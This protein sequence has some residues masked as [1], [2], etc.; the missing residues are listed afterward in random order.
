MPSRISPHHERPA[1]QPCRVAVHVFDPDGKFLHL[2]KPKPT[3]FPRELWSTTLTITDQGHVYL[4]LGNVS[5]GRRGDY[6]HFSADGKR[7]GTKRLKTEQWYFQPGTGNGLAL[8]YEEAYLVNPAGKTIR[9]IKRRPDGNWLV[10]PHHASVAPDGSFAI[11]TYFQTP[12]TVNIYKADGEPVRTVTMP[13][14][15]GSIPNI[16]Y[17]SKRLVAAGSGYL[18]IFDSSGSPIQS[19]RSASKGA[20][21]EAGCS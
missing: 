3:D 6:L 1:S 17:N 18:V 8:G 13:P 16:A 14:S 5:W 20:E 9:T 2:C 11:V 10:G 7:L 12:V 15:L 4:S 19:F 21:D